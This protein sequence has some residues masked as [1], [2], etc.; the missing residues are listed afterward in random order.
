MSTLAELIA[1]HFD[2]DPDV[3]TAAVF[4]AASVPQKWREMF[5]QVVRDECRRSA[6]TV[7]RRHERGVDDADQFDTPDANRDPTPNRET[8]RVCHI[9]GVTV[10]LADHIFCGMKHGNVLKGD[11]TADQWEARAAFLGAQ[12]AGISK[13]MDECIT[14]AKHLRDTGADSLAALELVSA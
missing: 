4:A 10:F 12:V 1:D 5:Y 2:P 7:V 14:V 11:A 3:T 8:R 9:G 6:R 13:T